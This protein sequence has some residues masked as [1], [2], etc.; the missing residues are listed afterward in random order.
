M[1]LRR[2]SAA[3]NLIQNP[4][5]ETANASDST[6]PNSW[7]KNSNGTN[8]AVFAYNNQAHSGTKAVT[9][10]LSNYQSGDAKWY[11]NHT[12][13]SPNT[14]Y[15]YSDWRK[16]STTSAV[17]VEFLS[18]AGKYTYK[19]IADAPT[20][21]AWK[22]DSFVF[23][24]LANTKSVSILHLISSNGYLTIDDVSLEP[25][26]APIAPKFNR[27]LVTVTFDDGFRSV[28]NNAL[29]IMNK[30]GILSTHYL[31]TDYLNQKTYMTDAMVKSLS[32]AGNEIGSHTVTHPELTL[33][34]ATTLNDELINS[35]S[36]LEILTGQTINSFATPYGEYNDQVVNA[37]KPIYK[38]HRTIVNGQN[39]KSGFDQYR[40]KSYMVEKNTPVT[41]VK[42][43]I[44]SAKL[45]NTWLV[46]TYH[47]VKN[48][49]W[50]YN[51]KPADFESD[52]ANIKNSG[53]TVLTLDKALSEIKTQL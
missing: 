16:S 45:N 7:N 33:S 13:V 41:T 14:S 40:I 15:S 36:L 25:Y 46:L 49:S 8:S 29:P 52:M 2:A 53:I 47:E 11:A 31:V 3:T 21:G 20:A 24:T 51:R 30:Y 19:W 4:G 50:Q 23:K 39:T 5:F 26:T 12:T 1:P 34:T 38:S 9:V 42:K 28:Y 10:T 43:W 48:S 27:P 17:M 44:D 32:S 37:I 6:M 35:K 18:T 22:Q